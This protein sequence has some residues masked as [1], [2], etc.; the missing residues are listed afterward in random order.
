MHL[1]SDFAET[2]KEMAGDTGHI[3]YVHEP[4]DGAS[5]RIRL[6]KLLPDLDEAGHIRC[7]LNQFSLATAP[8]YHALSYEWG[9]SHP[10]HKILIENAT[11]D[12]RPNLWLFLDMFRQRT[13]DDDDISCYLWIDQLCIDQSSNSER[14]HQVTLMGGIYSKA[15]TVRVWLGPSDGVRTAGLEAWA[16]RAFCSSCEAAY[17][18]P[19]SDLRKDIAR[20]NK[21]KDIG[22]LT[23][24]ACAK[25]RFLGDYFQVR[26]NKIDVVHQR[27]LKG[28]WELSYWSRM[29][30]I[31]E[32]V[33]AKDATFYLGKSRI[34]RKVIREYFLY[35]HPND[36]SMQ[37]FLTVL[38]VPESAFSERTLTGIMDGLGSDHLQCTN[39]RD[40]VFALMGMVEAANRIP[41]DY[42]IPTVKLCEIVL[43]EIVVE[44]T[45]RV[46][47]GLL[48]GYAQLI[49][50]KLGLP[51]RWQVWL[52]LPPTPIAETAVL[53][54]L[55]KSFKSL[56]AFRFCK[57]KWSLHEL[58]AIV[59]AWG[60]PLI[61]TGD[62]YGK[63]ALN[64]SLISK[65]N[66][67]NVSELPDVL[68]DL[69]GREF[70]TEHHEPVAWRD[71]I[72]P[73]WHPVFR[74]RGCQC[75]YSRETN[76]A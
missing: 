9:P 57:A 58:V 31:Q 13:D 3:E 51:C 7:E 65:F 6:M 34:S 72:K 32:N 25:C 44:P 66:S 76:Q 10:Q 15:T 64:M 17:G 40:L 62:P 35:S 26:S 1:Y 19:L 69:N 24:E 23:Q 53:Q 20:L 61:R 16:K 56:G 18:G 38:T 60:T 5:D 75:E 68:E 43:A 54:N 74:K 4:L 12:I 36:R 49:A 63:F 50:T 42:D 39:P 70:L 55:L 46:G 27:S 11:L 22:R 59:L 2:T 37:Q 48:I 71:M 33:L 73:D 47:A 8:P 67:I 21:H 41:I 29:W 45:R 28:I 52:D 30:I 14:N